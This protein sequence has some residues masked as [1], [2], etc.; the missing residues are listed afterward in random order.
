VTHPFHPLH[1]RRFRLLMYRHNWGENRVFF[2][3]DQG[4]TRWLPAAW[5]SV[6]PSDPFV[7][8]AA[9]RAAFRARDLLELARLI[10]VLQ[11]KPARGR[12]RKV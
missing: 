3:D 7:V 10:D 1:G 12:S 11:P 9:G 5:T 8:M 2:V 4:Q 6:E